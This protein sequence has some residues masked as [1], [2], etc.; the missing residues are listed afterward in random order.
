MEIKR[1]RFAVMRNNQ[2]E[3]WCGLARHYHFVLISELKDATI[4]TYRTRKQAES[5]C[6]SWDDNFEV[7][8]VIESLK[9]V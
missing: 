3:I 7:V 8:E 4:K 6:S 2:S 5:S 9:V 1:T